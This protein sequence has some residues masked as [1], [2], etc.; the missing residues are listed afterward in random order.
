[1]KKVFTILIT[2]LLALSLIGV[3][4]AADDP[5]LN[6]YDPSKYEQISDAGSDVDVHYSVGQEVVVLIPNDVSF[7][8]GVLHIHDNSAVFLFSLWTFSPFCWIIKRKWSGSLFQ[9]S[10][11]QEE[12][13]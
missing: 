9:K 5:V 7:S 11:F 4:S 2:F 13:S 1:M 8:E 3:A 10:F 12:I 6:D